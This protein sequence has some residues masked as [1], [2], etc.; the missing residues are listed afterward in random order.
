MFS[1]SS[2]WGT[3]Q[4]PRKVHLGLDRGEQARSLSPWLLDVVA[5]SSAHRL[6]SSAHTCPRGHGDHRQ[7]LIQ[8]AQG[9]EQAQSF[10]SGGGVAGV[11][12]IEQDQIEIA[13]LD[14]APDRIAGT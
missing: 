3:P 7:S 6:Y 2:R 5:A 4:R 12:Q 14:C 10:L 11:V 1:V 9:P 8:L 13:L